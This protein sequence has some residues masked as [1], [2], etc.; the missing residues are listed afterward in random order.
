MSTLGLLP[1][2]GEFSVRGDDGSGVFS[3]NQFNRRILRY[4]PML[5][6]VQRLNIDF[7]D[8]RNFVAKS[9][10]R[11]GRSMPAG[12]LFLMEPK[13]AL[14][15]IIYIIGLFEHLGDFRL[16]PEDAGLLEEPA[17]HLTLIP[18]F[19]PPLRGCLVLAGFTRAGLL[20]DMIDLLG[21][22]RF[23]R[24]ELLYVSRVQ[25]LLNT[26]AKTL[27][28]VLLYPS[29]PLGEQLSLAG[30]PVLMILQRL[31]SFITS[32]YHRI[33]CFARSRSRR[34]PSLMI[35]RRA[36]ACSSSTYSRPSRPLCSPPLRSYTTK[37]ISVA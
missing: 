13:G 33:S 22:I 26:C 10:L 30:I 7:L 12:D 2:V 27:E 25:L 24:T 21:R 35:R 18:L 19:I 28:E 36:P 3:S 14:R 17:D 1:L 32:T 15:Q 34:S 8:I 9:R 20:K 6:N 11:F 5:I 29:D 4:C 37:T 23:R 16:L 31:C